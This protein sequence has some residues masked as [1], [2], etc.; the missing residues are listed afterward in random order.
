MMQPFNS[1]ISVSSFI[2]NPT[3]LKT[4]YLGTLWVPQYRF[5]VKKFEILEA[6]E[7]VGISSIRSL[8]FLGHHQRGF[9]LRG[10]FTVHITRVH[11]ST[12]VYKSWTK[13]HET[14]A[15]SR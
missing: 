9:V 1:T 11:D 14:M 12:Y 5:R 15:A 6:L 4:V 13:V 8:Y 10:S 7:P 2:H 3:L